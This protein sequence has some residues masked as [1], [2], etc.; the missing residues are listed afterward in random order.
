MAVP[1]ILIQQL[2][3]TLF[4]SI[5]DFYFVFKPIGGKKS[6]FKRTFLYPCVYK[7]AD[8]VVVEEFLLFSWVILSE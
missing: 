1:T 8:T 3:E 2:K 7:G 6:I 5:F 4:S